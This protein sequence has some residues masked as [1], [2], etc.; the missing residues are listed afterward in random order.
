M[1][2]VQE[3]LTKHKVIITIQLLLAS[4]T[5]TNNNNGIKCIYT[6]TQA[7]V[8]VAKPVVKVAKALVVVDK[9]Y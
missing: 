3:Q 1:Y 7:V 2:V 6:C 9:N 4:Y 8:V 5:N